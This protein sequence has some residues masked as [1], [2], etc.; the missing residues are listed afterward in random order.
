MAPQ[1]APQ[2]IYVQ[3]P[4]MV[5]A[6]PPANPDCA[7]YGH[8]TRIGCCGLCGVVCCFPWSL[9]WLFG[10]RTVTCKRCDAKMPPQGVLG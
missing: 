4:G 8:E 1:M 6:A 2:Q 5:Q 9:I 3:N 10:R 7:Q